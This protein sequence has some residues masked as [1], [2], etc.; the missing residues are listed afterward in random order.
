MKKG[1]IP[2]IIITIIVG[3][4]IILYA[5]G[6]SIGLIETHIPFGIVLFVALIFLI[7][8]IM[9]IYTLISRIKEIKGENEDDI[10]KY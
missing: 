1:V 7:I 4:F 5:V 9:L 8:L 6:I 10:S 3:T 2:A